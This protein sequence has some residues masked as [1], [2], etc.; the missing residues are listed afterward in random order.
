MVYSRA[1]TSAMALRPVDLPALPDFGGIAGKILELVA[2]E[3]A[4]LSNGL[5]LTRLTYRNC[6]ENAVRS[7]Q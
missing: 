2:S 4:K 7:A 1:T 3:A 5:E 6:N